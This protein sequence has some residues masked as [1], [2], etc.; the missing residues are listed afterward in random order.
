MRRY[1]VSASLVAVVDDDTKLPAPSTSSDGV[2]VGAD[3]EEV[4]WYVDLN[5]WSTDSG[6]A[7]CWY[8]DTVGDVWVPGKELTVNA[9]NGGVI[10]QKCLGDRVDLQ[11]KTMTGQADAV[12]YRFGK[13]VD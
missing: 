1:T 13:V 9:T 8:Y 6:T 2:A 7:V 5:D 12:R 11:L 3:A 4:V 10:V